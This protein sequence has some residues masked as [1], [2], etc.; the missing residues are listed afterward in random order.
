MDYRKDKK[1]NRLWSVRLFRTSFTL[2]DACGAEQNVGFSS[3]GIQIGLGQGEYS[4]KQR[5][6]PALSQQLQSPPSLGHR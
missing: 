1:V 4:T 2:S 6:I 5:I 3:A